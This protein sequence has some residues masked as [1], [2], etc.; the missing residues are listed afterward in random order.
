MNFV[1]FVSF[2]KWVVN[3]YWQW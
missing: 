1:K 3:D 2:G